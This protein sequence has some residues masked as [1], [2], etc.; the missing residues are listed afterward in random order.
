VALVLLAAITALAVSQSACAGTSSA[1]LG[2][3]TNS[4]PLASGHRAPDFTLPS[5]HA[6]TVSLHQYSGQVVVLELF[7]PWSPH[8]QSQ[9]RV[10][11]AIQ[12]A[13][14]VLG[15]QMLSVSASPF[16]RNY[17]NSDGTDRTPISMRDITWFADTFSLNYPA[18]LDTSLRTAN[19]YGLYS[20]PA[21]FVI[22]RHGV[23]T[24]KN[25]QGGETSYSD[26]QLQIDRALRR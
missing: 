24:W 14:A 6:G 17:E 3:I 2:H 21:L 10:L 9:T 22:D 26:L 16:G 23:I 20:Y 18:L 25:G 1:S 8:C 4:T 11:T 13:N 7:A 12:A 19:A 5:A 15:V